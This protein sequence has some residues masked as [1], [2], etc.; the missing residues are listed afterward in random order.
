MRKLLVS[1]VNKTLGCKSI[2]IQQS[3]FRSQLLA[4]IEEHLNITIQQ[5][6]KDL[7][8]PV[9]EFDG[10]V[11]YG[12]KL[13]KKGTGY[14]DHVKQLAPIV[15]NLATLERK[16]QTAFLKYMKVQ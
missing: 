1:F 11:V 3:L 4:D 12:E 9:N 14:E 6:D 7:N 5:V 10:K 13:Q 15:Q 2:L 16:A 8:V